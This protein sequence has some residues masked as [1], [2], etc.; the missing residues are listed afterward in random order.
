MANKDI[1][2]ATIVTVVDGNDSVFI[3]QDDNKLRKIN[4]EV[5]VN[6]AKGYV[7]LELTTN[8]SVA[9][10]TDIV[11]CTGNLTA[12]LGDPATAT[13]PVTIRN[14]SGT[15]TVTSTVGTV[16]QTTLTVGQSFTY[17]PRTT[18]TEWKVI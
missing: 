3:S 5:F 14:I 8:G 16:E 1:N 18:T 13:G 6:A 4:F 17:S 9:D 11:W 12:T 15:T 7:E 10:T 2:T